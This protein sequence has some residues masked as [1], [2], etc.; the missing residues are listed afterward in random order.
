MGSPEFSV[1]ILAALAKAYPVCGVFTQPDRPSGRGMKLTPPPVKDLAVSLG[2]P[3]FQPDKVNQDASFDYIQKWN[4]DL[5]VVAAYGQIL[6]P[7]ILNF[8][9]YGCIN[10][11]ASLLPRWRGASPI[12]SALVAGD[13][14]TGISIMKMDV[15]M[16]TGDILG[17]LEVPILS[18]D[19]GGSL[20]EKLSILGAEY[21]QEVLL[22]YIAGELKAYPQ[23]EVGITYASLI[24][25]K[26]GQLN[27]ASEHAVTLER[28]VRAYQPWPGAYLEWEGGRLK[29]WEATVISDEMPTGENRSIKDGWPIVATA[30]GSLKL[31]LVQP[32][33]KNRMTG[34]QFLCGAKN[35]SKVPSNKAG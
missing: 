7:K 2:I 10:V 30:F 13:T 29:V 12:Q 16:D 4:P 22:A 19:T 28:M 20:T 5:I 14:K 3:V 18:T 24:Q 1:P 34:K 32:A 15:G 35:W 9:K 26:D 6:K 33:G 23:Q 27:P 31:D 11:H 8:P 25:K 17:L 21:L